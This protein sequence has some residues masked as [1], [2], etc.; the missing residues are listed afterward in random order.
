MVPVITTSPADLRVVSF[1]NATFNCTATANPRAV[2]QWTKNEIVLNDTMEIFIISYY[3]EG[4][5]IITDPHSDCVITSTLDINDVVPNDSGEYVCTAINA[6]GNDTA[7]GSLTVHGKYSV[8]S[9][10]QIFVKLL[11]FSLLHYNYILI[12]FWYVL[13]M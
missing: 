4:N 1:D 3:K 13:A 7:S 8:V 2:I 10:I 11:A 12:V 9:V 6:A 5:C